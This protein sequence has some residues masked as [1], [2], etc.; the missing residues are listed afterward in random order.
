MICPS[1]R[2]APIS[3][4]IRDHLKLPALLARRPTAR[5]HILDAEQHVSV[6]AENIIAALRRP[7]LGTLPDDGSVLRECDSG[8]HHLVVAQLQGDTAFLGHVVHAQHRVRRPC[9]SART[10]RF[11]QACREKDARDVVQLH[12]FRGGK[13]NNWR[14]AP[15]S[16]PTQR[17]RGGIV[18]RRSGRLAMAGDGEWRWGL[19]GEDPGEEEA[20]GQ[21]RRGGGLK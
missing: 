8:W 14:S 10:R 3:L 7:R 21:T 13:V 20:E 11:R 12:A 1:P 5:P 19:P 15:R 18:E 6:R 9:G 4:F 17:S 16:T 2:V